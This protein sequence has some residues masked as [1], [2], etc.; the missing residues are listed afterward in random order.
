MPYAFKANTINLAVDY[1]VRPHADLG[2]KIWKNRKD[3]T[4]GRIFMLF[5]FDHLRLP[6]VRF[7]DPRCS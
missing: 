1:L 7:G 2:G 4:R 5:A 6:L 3:A